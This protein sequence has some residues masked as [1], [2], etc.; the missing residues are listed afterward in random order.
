MS[1]I[2]KIGFISL[3]FFIPSIAL[4]FE[5]SDLTTAEFW[6][7]YAVILLA[8]SEWLGSTDVVKSNSVLSFLVNLIKKAF[9]K[10]TPV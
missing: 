6:A 2:K 9:K 5:W 7:P 8:I 4:A 1:L 10:D 3:L